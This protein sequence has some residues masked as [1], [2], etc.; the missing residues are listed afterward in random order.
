[1]NYNLLNGIADTIQAP[2]KFLSFIGNNWLGLV[3]GLG[4]A[5]LISLIILLVT[6]QM[7]NAVICV[8]LA[9]IC[10]VGGLFICSK[11]KPSKD[12]SSLP[13]SG[14]RGQDL[15]IVSGDNWENTNGGFT[16]E[17]I[18]NAQK[19]DECPALN[20]MNI[21]YEMRDFGDYVNFLYTNDSTYYNAMFV[22]TDNG[23]C[24]VGLL[25]ASCAMDDTGM[26]FWRKYSLDT[27][28]WYEMNTKNSYHGVKVPEW[29]KYDRTFLGLA[30]HYNTFVNNFETDLGFSR[31]NFSWQ[32]KNASEAKKLTYN[33]AVEFVGKNSN[34][35]NHFG[36]IE[37]IGDYKQATQDKMAL[38]YINTYFNHLYSECKNV[39]INNSK[40][41]DVTNLT[42][43]P[44]AEEERENYPVSD[45]FKKSYPDIDYYAV[46]RVNTFATIDVRKANKDLQTSG[47]IDNVIEKNKDDDKF[48]V[49]PTPKQEKEYS[50]VSV[51]LKNKTEN[52][53][54]A[55]VNLKTNPI[56]ITFKE[57]ISGE[58]KVVTI[59]S[60]DNLSKIQY[61]GLQKNKTYD[62]T[63]SSNTLQ[64]EYYY[65]SFDVKSIDTKVE[66]SFE[67]KNGYINAQFGLNVVTSLDLSVID[68]KKNPVKI[69]LTNSSNTYEILLDDNKYIS[70]KVIKSIKLGK[71]N[72]SLLSNQLAFITESGEIEI[73]NEHYIMSFNCG[74]RENT[75]NDDFSYDLDIKDGSGLYSY[76]ITLRSL[77]D[78]ITI[79]ITDINGRLAVR[80]SLVDMSPYF[81]ETE[82]G[83][84]YFIKNVVPKQNG[85][86]L[87]SNKYY[88]VI[89]K[90]YF[91]D[92]IITSNVKGFTYTNSFNIVVNE[93]SVGIIEP[94]PNL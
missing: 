15:A 7:P 74:V 56:V 66:F 12:D 25:G 33:K 48:K 57:R 28:K 76:E 27:F 45:E 55:D 40:V 52:V 17:Q 24:Y 93:V 38:Q 31:N 78:Y 87:I 29:K 1:M 71:Y 60:I 14:E 63:I 42:C 9:I 75:G 43:V 11:L 39:E 20:D 46:Y 65:G 32:F 79:E 49:K 26:L 91:G 67:Y 23:L 16:F 36:E 59:D 90:A 61:V 5:V 2:F 72:Y 69:L 34:A 73:T 30:G 68:L 92:K 3:I 64:F 86:N 41:V 44:I 18:Q 84:Y 62:Y 54:L 94:T 4:V 8:L 53:S 19:D 47:S 35:F 88:N 80:E 89:F 70:E 6:K 77:P 85:I 21:N 81:V 51:V 83:G 58:S 50:I 13:D 22:K 10:G 37:L 82:D